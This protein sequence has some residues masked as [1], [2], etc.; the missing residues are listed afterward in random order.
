MPQQNNPLQR[1]RRTANIDSTEV[2]C[3]DMEIFKSGRSRM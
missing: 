2:S 3:G 1:R